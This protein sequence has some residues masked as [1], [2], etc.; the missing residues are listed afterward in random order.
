MD[1]KPN[2]WNQCNFKHEGWNARHSKADDLTL[3]LSGHLEAS[4]ILFWIVGLPLL[5]FNPTTPNA[6]SFFGW[7]LSTPAPQLIS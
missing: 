6:H 7:W 4:Y 1:N 2:Y 5:L 3:P